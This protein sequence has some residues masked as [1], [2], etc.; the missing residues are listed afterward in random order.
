[1]HIFNASD[2]QIAGAMRGPLAYSYKEPVRSILKSLA[3]PMER[4]SQFLS[5][6]AHEEYR[7]LC[8]WE[9]LDLADANSAMDTY[10]ADHLNTM[11]EE[12]AR[13]L[14]GTLLEAAVNN[15]LGNHQMKGITS[16]QHAE[17]GADFLYDAF[18]FEPDETRQI[19]PGPEPV[20]GLLVFL[21]QIVSPRFS[22]LREYQK[23]Y[24]SDPSGCNVSGCFASILDFDY[25]IGDCP[26]APSH[27]DDQIILMHK[28]SCL[29][30]SY[31]K[32]LAAYNPWNDI[33]DDDESIRRVTRAVTE[34]GFI[35]VKIYPHLGYYPGNNS[36]LP[37][38]K[39]GRHPDFGLLDE[40]LRHF[41]R[42]C[43]RLDIP[44]MAHS[45][46]SMGRD[47]DHNVLGSPAA[48][49]HFFA[50][51]E[52]AGTRIN[53]AHIGGEEGGGPGPGGWTA[54]FSGLMKAPGCEWLYGDF[55]YWDGLTS[56]SDASLQ[57]ILEVLDKQVS[58]NE[59]VADRLMFG[60]DWLMLSFTYPRR[61]YAGEFLAKLAD[62]HV[63]TD[64]LE[65]IF[66]LNAKRLFRQVES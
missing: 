51:E 21:R 46:E 4:V 57:R 24:S 19:A 16:A 28:I 29:S 8:H 44:V 38:P 2:W 22:N 27:L 50:N 5:L 36:T 7:N 14:R 56:G 12:L 63:P 59:T 34:F 3:T 13:L 9:T 25:W 1:M 47:T 58:N 6:S 37:Y 60:S 43:R 49:G 62:H 30:G 41:F 23:L 15:L 65:K 39:K 48:W 52:N 18:T 26:H 61:N 31:M 53:L 10:I 45:E 11:A 64:I 55:G 42:E 32:P 20:E 33:N 54:D 66:H 35:G 40:K 17:F